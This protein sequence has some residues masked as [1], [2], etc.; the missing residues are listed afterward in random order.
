MTADNPVY[1]KYFLCCLL[2]SADWGRAL[3][4]PPSRNAPAHAR[5]IHYEQH[6]IVVSAL[7]IVVHTS[8][9]GHCELGNL[10]TM[11][12]ANTARFIWFAHP[13]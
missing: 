2:I 6:V 11:S 5:D 13:P 12:G 9:M 8:N 10:V 4:L 3:W 7:Y 1:L